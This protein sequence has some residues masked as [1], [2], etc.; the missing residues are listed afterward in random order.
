MSHCLSNLPAFDVKDR[1]YSDYRESLNALDFL[2]GIFG[3]CAR[4]RRGI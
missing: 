4:Q 2:E 1:M 3:D